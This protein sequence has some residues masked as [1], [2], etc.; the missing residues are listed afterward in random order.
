MP[1][2]T[3]VSRRSEALYAAS[4]VRRLV[5]RPVR[6]SF[7]EGGSP[8]SAGPTKADVSRRSFTRR[9][10][11]SRTRRATDLPVAQTRPR[12][13]L[14]RKRTTD[15]TGGAN[16]RHLSQQ[17]HIK[18]PVESST[19]AA[20]RPAKLSGSDTTSRTNGSSNCHHL[21]DDFQTLWLD[22]SRRQ[23]FRL[24]KAQSV[25]LTPEAAT[26]V[27]SW[28][29]VAESD[30]D[31]EFEQPIKAEPTLSVVLVTSKST[32]CRSDPLH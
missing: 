24:R 28:R 9:R 20:P 22:R 19:I 29:W 32:L 25:A 12:S 31:G 11:P 3:G 15:F 30:I 23:Q 27:Q 7:S 10:K 18:E 26:R 13:I 2:L 21:Q 14:G 1:R 8:A 16:H 17:L 5:R 6:R 4:R